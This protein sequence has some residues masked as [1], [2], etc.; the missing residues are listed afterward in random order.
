MEVII[1]TI[2]CTFVLGSEEQRIQ[3]TEELMGE[4]VVQLSQDSF[5]SE[6]EKMAHFVMFTYRASH[7]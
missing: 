7:P 2:F 6:L 1:A 5:A 3:D 4:D